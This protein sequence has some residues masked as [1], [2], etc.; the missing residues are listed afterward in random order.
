MAQRVGGI[1][2]GGAASREV[3]GE[4]RDGKQE[5]WD[6][7]K[8]DRVVGAD[9]VEDPSQDLG[10]GGGDSDTND[11]A[12]DDGAHGLPQNERHDVAAVSTQGEADA[13]FAEA[14]ADAERDDAVDA[15]G[16]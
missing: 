5:K 2:A 11:A 10:D 8:R 9:A 13:D 12:D 7:G 16:G 1:E 14:L 6:A 15:D 4:E 3:A